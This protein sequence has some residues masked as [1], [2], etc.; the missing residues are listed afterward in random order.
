M[1]AGWRTRMKSG[2]RVSELSMV[3]Y[4]NMLFS[5]V[6]MMIDYDCLQTKMLHISLIAT[7]TSSTKIQECF[8][9][10]Y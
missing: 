7:C 3:I 2:H 5:D 9:G 4:R 8:K 6:P 1:Y 10:V